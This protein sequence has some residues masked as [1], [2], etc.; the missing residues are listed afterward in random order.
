MRKKSLKPLSVAAKI[1][2]MKEEG[3]VKPKIMKEKPCRGFL[4][5]KEGEILNQFGLGKLE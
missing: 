1:K 5:G 4:G 2:S 3:A